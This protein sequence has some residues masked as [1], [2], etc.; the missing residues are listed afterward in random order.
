[1]T[2]QN[3]LSPIL[4]QALAS[5]WYQLG[6]FA[7]NDILF[8][9]VISTA[10]GES[11]DA[12]SFQTAWAKGNFS[13]FPPIEVRNRSEINEANGAFAFAT[14]KIYLSQEFID[15]NVNNVG[16]I[17]AVLLEEYGH[18]VDSKINLTD[19]AGDEGDIFARLVQG[20]GISESELAVLKAEDDSAIVM[21]DGQLVQIEQAGYCNWH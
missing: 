9:S 18:Y 21:L 16:V 17:T 5:V 14:G 1:M 2:T 6:Q 8:N 4:N 20:E 15:A 7:S 10:F 19:S 12:S 11:A 13:G 3:L